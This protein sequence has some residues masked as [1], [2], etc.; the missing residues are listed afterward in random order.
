M[1][2]VL[3]SSLPSSRRFVS[4]HDAMG[5]LNTIVKHANTLWVHALSSNMPVRE[6]GSRSWW[7]EK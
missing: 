2:L 3:A 6:G 4:I 7:L 5:D 1:G